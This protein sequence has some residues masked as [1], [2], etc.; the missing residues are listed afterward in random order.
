MS[1]A[2]SRAE[3]HADAEPETVRSSRRTVR[4]A[5]E[6]HAVGRENALSGAALAGKVPL[7]PTTVRDV[8]SE[9]RDDGE[10]PIGNSPGGYY[11]IDNA[12]EL[13]AWVEAKRE[14][15]ATMRSRMETVTESFNQRRYDG[16]DE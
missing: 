16:G 14:E 2:G 11:V 15:I 10:L 3:H 4:Q 8:V 5:L 7:E 1:N 12:D 13:D 9:L 6:R